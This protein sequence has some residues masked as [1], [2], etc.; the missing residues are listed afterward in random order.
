MRKIFWIGFLILFFH[1]ALAQ[2]NPDGSVKGIVTNAENEAQP[3]VMIWTEP[4]STEVFT[5]ANG[6]YSMTLK[7]GKYTLFVGENGSPIQS[8][9]IFVQS[10]KTVQYDFMLEGV[11]QLSTVQ[12]F[13]SVNKQPEKL[14]QITRLPLKPNENIQTI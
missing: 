11:V 14:D 5:N 4:Y 2:S 3:Y 1:Q 8:Q 10:N 6:E 9:N 13:G 7:P 12:L